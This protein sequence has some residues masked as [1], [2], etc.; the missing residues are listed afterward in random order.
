LF[1]LLGWGW[2]WVA[3]GRGWGGKERRESV[4]DPFG[5]S[6]DDTKYGRNK[7][8]GNKPHENETNE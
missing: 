2:G 4:C 6:T 1:V 5:S 3:G 8:A 7:K